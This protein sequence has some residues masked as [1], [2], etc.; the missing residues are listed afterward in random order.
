MRTRWYMGWLGACL[1][2]FGPASAAEYPSFVLKPVDSRPGVAMFETADVDGDNRIEAIELTADR[3]HFFVRK[4]S[5]AAVIGPA[6]YQ[7]NCA[8][9]IGRITP[10]EIDP[11]PGMELAIAYKDRT[12]DSAWVA[13]VAG[14]DKDRV[15]CRTKAVRGVNIADRGGP[16]DYGWDG[17]IGRCYAVDLNRDGVCEIVLSVGVG[18][19]LYPRGIYVYEYPSGRLL[20]QF[21]TAANPGEIQFQDVNDDTHLEVFFKTYA[22]SNGAVVGDQSDSTAD[23]FALDN[24]G[25]LLWRTGTGDRFEFSTSNIAVC[26]CDGDDTPEIYYSTLARSDDLDRQLQVLEKHRAS[27]NQFIEQRLF[28]APH[29]FQQIVLGA[30]GRDS[31][32]EILLNNGPLIVDPVTLRTISEGSVPRGSIEYAGSLGLAVSMPPNRYVGN[33]RSETTSPGLILKKDDSLYIMDG[34]WNLLAAYGTSYGQPIGA[35]TYFRSPAGGDYLG[36]LVDASEPGKPGSVLNILAVVPTEGDVVSN[37]WKN[38]LRAWVTVVVAFLIG[39]PT[40]IVLFKKFSR[41]PRP[42]VGHLVAYEDLLSALTTFG[43]GQM[44]GRNLTRLAFLFSNLPEDPKKMEEIL[45]NI[46]SALEAYRSFTAGQLDAIA[47]H[48]RHIPTIHS[49]VAELAKH[50]E[51]LNTLFNDTAPTQ[52]SIDDLVHL[53]AAVPRTIESL[54]HRIKQLEARIQP[55]FGSDLIKV[56]PGVL[57]ANSGFIRKHKV[58]ISQV[59][60]VG[61]Y[62]HLAF[63]PPAELAAV[64]E[65]LITNACRAM[66]EAT[67][68]KLSFRL[69]YTIDQ[70]II[71]LSDTGVGL[72]V[73]DPEILFSRQYSTKGKEGGFG[74]H[75]ARQRIERFGGKISIRNNGDGPGATVRMVFKGVPHD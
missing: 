53:K 50:T 2:L 6:L 68:R 31:L 7:A 14:A 43:H 75:H 9:P 33:V 72:R 60:I 13:I 49:A 58:K 67:T 71:E 56:I 61:D 44:A 11:T 32:I 39:I 55:V 62:V 35:V 42:D 59:V 47:A 34:N 25:Q 74:L 26:D 30:R 4:F 29:R 17:G 66:E 40:G 27:D 51:Q 22:T 1:L 69:E 16:E 52:V 37:W 36:L 28:D 10:V 5:R 20:W 18:F 3:Y 63:F 38:A 73:D 64:M 70:V 8:Y 12:G 15:L 65:E 19:D 24:A 23:I 46:Q 48:G 57:I 41:A 45:P 21:P 54:R